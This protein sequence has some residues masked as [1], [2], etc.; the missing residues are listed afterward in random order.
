MRTGQQYRR[1]PLPIE[2]TTQVLA[3]RVDY[4]PTPMRITD[5]GHSAVARPVL[6]TRGEG[7]GELAEILSEIEPVR[8]TGDVTESV[9]RHRAELLVSR[10]IAAGFDLVNNASPIG[11][12]VDQA[13]A[14]VA[15]AAG[16][17]H[18]LLA[19]RL[20]RRLAERLGLD[21][22]VTSAYQEDDD[23]GRAVAAVERL[24]EDEPRIEYRITQATD[25]ADLVRQLPERSILVIGAPGGGWLQRNFLG[26]G[27]KLRSEAAAGA[28]VVRR[29]PDKVFQVME[30]PVF[31]GPYREAI[32]VLRLHSEEVLA[33]VDRAELIG[34][35]RRGAL[36]VADPGVP[37]QSVME[38]PVSV[39]MQAAVEEAMVL[40]PR[41]SGAAIPVVDDDGLLVGALPVP[42]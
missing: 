22:L 15:A 40:A 24:Y 34:I 28:V 39:E 27:A 35:V 20:A 12:E 26:A 1:L 8:V 30:D 33:V 32:D 18:S 38:A 10:R 3:P 4:G 11:L 37:V 29:Q 31:V 25:A 6:W 13:A 19:V 16:G 2:C 5:R 17:P 7:C 9:I 36:E 21:G 14:V 23:R 41:F 42:L